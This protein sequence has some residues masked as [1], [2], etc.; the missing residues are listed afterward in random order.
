MTSLKRR[1]TPQRHANVLQH[2]MGYLKDRIDGDDRRELVE[3]IESYRRGEVHLIVPIT[4]LR[5]YFRRNP[6][7]LSASPPGA[8]GTARADIAVG[9]ARPGD[10]TRGVSAGPLVHRHRGPAVPMSGG[11]WGS[12]GKELG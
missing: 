9:Q 3:S 2:I 11:P 12:I 6:D 7:P 8:A 4:L 1:V 10:C 5:H